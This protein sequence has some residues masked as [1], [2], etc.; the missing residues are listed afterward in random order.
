LLKCEAFSLGSPWEILIQYF[1]TFLFLG[2]FLS[3]QAFAQKKELRVATYV[4]PPHVFLAKDGPKPIGATIDFFN[5]YMNPQQKYD[6]KW[7]V[8][9]FARFLI[10]MENKKADVGLLLAKN[11]TREKQ[12]RFPSQSLFTTASGVIVSKNNK[13]KELKT[14]QDLKGM[15]LGHSQAS[16]TPPALVQAGIKFDYLSGD[17][18]ILRNIER[19]RL[20]RIDGV[21]VPTYLNAEYVIS[22]TTAAR[23]MQLFKIP[24]STLD[25]YIVFRKDLDQET[26]DYLS[27]QISKHRSSY[28]QMVKKYFAHPLREN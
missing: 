2:L 12:F 10:D 3:G 4:L 16:V 20:K 8:M 24:E 14:L 5:L 27:E 28:P 6:V 7:M 22:N 19:V 11:T 15:T 13:L 26:F 1:R 17:E 18:V 25:I 21:F 23:E 9:P